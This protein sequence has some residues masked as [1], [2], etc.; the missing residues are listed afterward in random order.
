MLFANIQLTGASVTHLLGHAGLLSPATVIG[1]ISLF[2]VAAIWRDWFV[3][4]KIHRLT[5]VLAIITFVLLP[6]EG[7]LIGPSAVWHQLVNCL[8]RIA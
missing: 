4:G 6:V 3:D 8:A 5:A 7:A 1:A 2:L